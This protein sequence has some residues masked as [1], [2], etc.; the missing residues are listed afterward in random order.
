MKNNI[1]QLVKSKEFLVFDFDGVILDSVGIKTDA[2][3]VL[4]SKFGNDVVTKVVTHHEK[5]GGVSRFEKFKYYHKEFLGKQLSYSDIEILNNEFSSLVLNKILIAKEIKGAISFI[6][7]TINDG[8]ICLINS[9]TPEDELVSIL[10]Q[11][12]YSKYFQLILGSPKTKFE[13]LKMI[14]SQFKCVSSDMIFFGDTVSDYEAA[15]K[16]GIDFIGLGGQGSILKGC[17]FSCPLIPDF[18]EIREKYLILG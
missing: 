17:K 2:F 16:A 1:L 11:R 14:K 6:E 13:N 7:D 5:N 3:R 12:N 18:A 4:Y 15:S 9:A 10:K 8:K